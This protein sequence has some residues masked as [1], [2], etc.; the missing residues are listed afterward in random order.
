MIKKLISVGAAV[1]RVSKIRLNIE[2]VSEIMD[3][4]DKN[5]DGEIDMIELLFGIVDY[6]RVKGGIK[7][8]P[9]A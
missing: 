7:K 5:D 9:K 3:K 4:I 8:A 6:A 2:D 1:M